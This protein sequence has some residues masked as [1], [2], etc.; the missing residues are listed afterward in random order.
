M[1]GFMSTPG[2][3]RALGCA[4]LLS[5][6]I[7]TFA[8]PPYVPFDEQ[9]WDLSRAR[10][11]THLN[12]VALR[13]AA[14]LRDVEFTNGVI[15]VD[16]AAAGRTYPGILFHQQAPGMSEHVYVRPH[17]AGLYPDALQYCP[18]FHGV[19][20]WQLYHGPG[21][22]NA[23]AWTPDQWTRMR[24]EVHGDQARVFLGDATQPDLVIP[25][26]IHG[27]G[28]GSIGI[29]GPPDGSAF[30]S[31]FRY[32]PDETLVFPDVEPPTAPA[33]TIMDWELS[34]SFGPTQIR[35]DEFPGAFQT[36]AAGWEPVSCEP[37]GL[38]NISRHRRR[39]GTGPDTVLARTRFYCT[40]PQTIGLTFA[41]SDDLRLFL[42]HDLVYSGRNGYRRRDPSYVG[43]LNPNDTVYVNVDAGQHQLLFSVTEA[44][45]GSGIICRT[46]P[47]L[48]PIAKRDDVLELLWETPADFQIPESVTYDP[49]REVLYVSNFNRLRREDAK[50]GFISR[51]NLDGTVAESKWITGLDGPSGLAVHE[52]T[53]YVCEAFSQLTA[54]DI[55]SGT[56]KTRYAAPETLAF[57]NDVAVTTDGRVFITNSSP[58]PEQDDIFTIE[59]GK[60]VTW[61]TGR[62]I[63]RANG[64][65]AV[66][67]ALIVGCVSDGVLRRVD[68]NSRQ[69]TPLVAM[70]AGIIDGISPAHD[71]Q[72]LVSHWDGPIYQVSPAG[73]MTQI[74]DTATT[75]CN[76]ANFEFVADHDLLVVPAF[77]GNK[78]VGYR[79][80]Q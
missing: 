30:F 60:L 37:D 31:N 50:T 20:C 51:L 53:L 58:Q 75:E 2:V 57:L 39:S 59:D 22:T 6:A 66:D 26:L 28:G 56:I 65:C 77:L 43:V 9:H 10:I 18:K 13:G 40:M 8:D 45:G 76:A 29:S 73:E 3:S 74:Y 71:G 15:E 27:A 64:L 23:T 80:R 33:G 19:G 32:W 68:L 70:G 54:I 41:Y 63:C 42:D 48:A 34:P 24:I 5:L 55:P 61:K 1:S 21:F 4:M 14:L 38:L 17:R 69:T 72:L 44:F 67:G 25:R 62:D 12:R 79:V 35:L 46:T 11:E 78:V 16:I 36:F 49:R 47:E 52:D 7:P